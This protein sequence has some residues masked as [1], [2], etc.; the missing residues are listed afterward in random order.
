MFCPH[1]G[2]E[3]TEGQLFC[4]SCGANLIAQI[5]EVV[6]AGGGRSKT[7]WEE[8]GTIGYVKGLF[9]T[10]QHVLFKPS[11][12]FKKMQITGGLTDPLLYALI[13]G[14]IGLMFFYFWQVLLKGV[15]QGFL[16]P[17]MAAAGPPMFEGVSIALLAILSPVLIITGLFLSA[18]ILHVCLMILQGARSGFEATCRVAAYAYSAHIFLVAPF[19]GGLVGGI[20]TIVI[21]II[22]L[23]EVHEITGGKAA[24]AV[25]FPLILCCGMAFLLIVMSM[26]A[27]VASFGTLM[28]MQR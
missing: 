8:R 2:K 17:Q 1:C 19:C 6:S 28:Q 21:T 16:P 14:M 15:T 25:F 27:L 18:G 13:M 22:G 4:S 20:Y 26:G 3:I 11:D 10:V 9:G 12:F 5:P 24:M 23:R 7:P